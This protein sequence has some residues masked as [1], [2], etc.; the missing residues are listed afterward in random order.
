M[1]RHVILILAVVLLAALQTT[2]IPMLLP[3]W[4]HPDL[5]LAVTVLVGLFMRPAAG[6]IYAFGMGYLQDL[7]TGSI[8][9]LFTFDRVVI[10]LLAYWLAG[11]FYAKSASAQALLVAVMAMLDYFLLLLLFTVFTGG[12]A[13]SAPLW[14]LI[15]RSLCSALAGL[16]LFYP[17]SILWEGAQREL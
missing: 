4:I 5:L 17:L 6:S 13:F 2:L 16:I 14:H 8:I 3:E 10:F 9:G 11:Q 1:S 7:L 12:E 15:P